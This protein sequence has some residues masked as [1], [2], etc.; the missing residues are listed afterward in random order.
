MVFHKGNQNLTHM[1]GMSLACS[2][3]P[4]LLQETGTSPSLCGGDRDRCCFL[5]EQSHVTV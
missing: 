2:A 1:D 5:W 3:I 4:P